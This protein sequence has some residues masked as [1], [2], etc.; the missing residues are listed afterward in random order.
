[1]NLT[2]PDS[3]VYR[4]QSTLACLPQTVIPLI[5]FI[6]NGLYYR[7]IFIPAGNTLVGRRHRFA[8]RN[9]CIGEFLVT[10]DPGSTRLSGY[11][12]INSIGGVKRVGHAISDTIWVTICPALSNNLLELPDLL[13]FTEPEEEQLAIANNF[14]EK[15]LWPSFQQL[16]QQ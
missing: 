2:C 12:I 6:A 13:T 1:M 11:N 3:A 14:T 16:P 10:T 15:L 7:A 9:I 4:M 5:E 8:N